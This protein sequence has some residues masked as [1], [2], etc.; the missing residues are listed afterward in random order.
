MPMYLYF[1]KRDFKT[2]DPS[3]K[4]GHQERYSHVKGAPSLDENS[5]GRT[6]YSNRFCSVDEQEQGFFI[7]LIAGFQGERRGWSAPGAEWPEVDTCIGSHML[8]DV[9][10][11][12]MRRVRSATQQ[13]QLHIRQPCCCV[14]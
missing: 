9:L 7:P 13:V 5:L 2:I 12:R 11:N 6:T 1:T 10:E 8:A 14:V 4:E 3:V